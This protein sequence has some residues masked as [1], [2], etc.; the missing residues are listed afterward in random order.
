MAIGGS[1]GIEEAQRVSRQ[2]AS[3]DEGW[4]AYELLCTKHCGS[5]GMMPETPLKGSIRK[6]QSPYEPRKLIHYL[7]S[8]ACELLR[9]GARQS[10]WHNASITVP[11]SLRLRWMRQVRRYVTGADAS[12]ILGRITF[13]FGKTFLAQ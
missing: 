10:W 9:E 8:H 13:L 5:I 12:A 4:K 3:R 1:V 11:R 2:E 7:Q 6:S